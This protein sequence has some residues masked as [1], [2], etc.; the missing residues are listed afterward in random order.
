MFLRIHV[1]KAWSPNYGV[2]GSWRNI[3]E[4]GTDGRK[5]G[6][7][8]CSIEGD[9]GVLACFLS[10]PFSSPLSSLLKGLKVLHSAM[11]SLACPL[12]YRTNIAGFK[13]YGLKKNVIFSGS[14]GTRL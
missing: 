6:D 4:V 12:F 3:Q 10:Q 11:H 14:G 9:L 8:R 7:Y 2:I 5:G 13:N 1:L